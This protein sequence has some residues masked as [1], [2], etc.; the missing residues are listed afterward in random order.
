MVLLG[1]FSQSIM[2]IFALAI[3]YIVVF[4]IYHIVTND[5][6]DPYQK[7]VWIIVILI[8]NILAS[9]IYLIIHNRAKFNAKWKF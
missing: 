2:L 4:S 7:V 8:G 1:I 9:I 3:M 6:L 5:K